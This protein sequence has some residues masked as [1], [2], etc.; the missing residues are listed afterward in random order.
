MAR[1]SEK[2]KA[3]L[4]ALMKDDVYEHAMAIIADEGL[5][6]LTM[7]RIASEVGVSRGTLYNYFSDKEAVVAYVE[8]RTFKPL[9]NEVDAIADG[10]LPP[11]DKLRMIAELVLNSVYDDKALVVAL[12]PNKFSNATLCC[13]VERRLGALQA[14]EKVIAQGIDLGIFK[15]LP[16]RLASETFLGAISGKIE[17]MALLDEFQSAEEIVPTMIEIILGG[18]EKA[19]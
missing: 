15:D 6:S 1:Y 5:G 3:A 18:L 2:Q 14:V 12:I 19:P 4:D 16:P 17:S 9:L 7:E 8:E 11:G 10:T 13:E